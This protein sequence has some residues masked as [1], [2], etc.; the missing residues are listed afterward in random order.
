VILW[1]VAPLDPS[2]DASEPGGALWFP[3][4]FQGSGRHD[5]P[6]RYG[7]LYVGTEAVAV[8]AETLAPFRGTGDL[9]DELLVRGGRR[10]SLAAIAMSGD[11]EL[12]DL[13]DPA[14]LE[15]ERLRPSR[16]ATRIRSVTQAQAR[17]LHETHP[18]AAGLRWWS[19]IEASWI[20]ATLFDRAASR[21]AV[22]QVAELHTGDE[23]VLAAAEFAG[24]A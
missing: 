8:V 17:E 4:A 21:L 1:R 10:L 16:V 13:D 6:D 2:A 20:N 14:T 18:D 9:A 5:N 7:C 15:A 24:L 11:A 3:R 22:E 19:T 12:L 23:T